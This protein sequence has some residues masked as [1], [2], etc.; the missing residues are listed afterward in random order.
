MADI[1]FSIIIPFKTPSSDLKE[2]LNEIQRLTFLNYEVILLPD[3]AI[4][5]VDLPNINKM[6]II[7]T[8]EVSSAIKRDIGA[9]RDRGKY[10]AFIDDAFPRPDWLDKAFQLFQNHSDV[11]AIGGPAITPDSDSLWAKVSGAVF[12]SRFSGGFPERYL[13]VPP[14]KF[15]DDWPSVN[16]IVR[17]DVFEEIGGFIFRV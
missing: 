15:I 4:N 16:F 9:S 12:L 17:K 14:A 3:N 6:V 2:C 1:I 7:P 8:G 11:A 5:S 13:P 10:L